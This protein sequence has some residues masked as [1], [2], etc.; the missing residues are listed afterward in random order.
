MSESRINVARR[1]RAAG[2]DVSSS[3]KAGGSGRLSAIL[4]IGVI[5]AASVYLMAHDQVDEALG[6]TATVVSDKSTTTGQVW[7]SVVT[8]FA[9]DAEEDPAQQSSAPDLTM[10]K[11]G[12]R[13]TTASQGRT[14]ATSDDDLLRLEP[15]T[16]ITISER[17]IIVSGLPAQ[18]I[19]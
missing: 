2:A 10:L 13:I 15:K 19:E 1:K 11:N 18:P 4:S 14:V 8:T 3:H 12:D 17:S 6:R 16:T 5:L 7:T 9:I